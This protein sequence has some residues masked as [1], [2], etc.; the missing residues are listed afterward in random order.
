MKRILFLM[1]VLAIATANASVAEPTAFERALKRGCFLNYL[2]SYGKLSIK[3]DLSKRVVL[4]PSAARK[5]KKFTG[6]TFSLSEKSGRKLFEK[7]FRLNEGILSEQTFDLAVTGECV[8]MFRFEGGDENAEVVYPLIREVFQWENF[9]LPDTSGKVYAPFTPVKA[10]EDSA[11]VVLRKYRLNGFGLLDSILA[12]S[13]DSEQAGARPETLKQRELLAGPS[14]IAGSISGNE[15]VWREKK[16]KKISSGPQAAEWECSARSGKLEIASKARLEYDGTLKVNMSLIPSGEVSLDRLFIDIPL[17]AE[18]VPYFHAVTDAIRINDAGVLPE[19]WKSPQ[20]RRGSEWQNSFVPYIYLGGAARGLAFFAENDKNWLTAKGDMNLPIQEIIRDG[21]TVTLRI[22]LCNTPSLLKDTCSIVFG[23]QAAP[24]KPLGDNWR[25]RLRT[26]PGFSGPVNPWGGLHCASMGPYRERWDIVDDIIA[27]QEGRAFNKDVF[28][29]KIKELNPPNVLG[30]NDY[31]TRQLYFASRKDRPIL[32]YH[33]ENQGSQI[34]R[35]WA[36]FQDEWGIDNYTPREWPDEDVLR[37]GFW[38]DPS[39]RINFCPSY[40][41]YGLYYANQW[42]KRGIGLYWDNDYPTPDFN[43]RVPGGAYL[44]ENGRI[45]PAVCFWNRREYH[46]RIFELQQYWS[47]KLGK[48]LVWSHHM[49]NTMI[50][51][52]N[53]F[54]T[55]ML[56]YELHSEKP[57]DSGYILSTSAGG[58]CG[59]I[60]NALYN[61]LG[62]NNPHFRKFK[63]QNP[64]ESDL[65]VWGTSA[66]Y[67]LSVHGK[68]GFGDTLTLFEKKYP[69]KLNPIRILTDFGYGT[70]KVE[71]CPLWENPSEFNTGTDQVIHLL[72][73]HR[74]TGKHLV[75]LQN[76][77]EKDVVLR[78]V[79]SGKKL[80]IPESMTPYQTLI[81]VEDQ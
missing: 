59:A 81:I 56:D 75:L 62:S 5:A 31:L 45:Q 50:L 22:Y 16:V 12:G 30:S 70:P 7:N 10:G 33:E 44:A 69:G 38:V 19:A 67:E 68:Y 29:A 66:V 11:E 79:F 8:A 17:R 64:Y 27:S 47:E 23:L 28:T 20:A 40:I 71:V 53:G 39:S 57:F 35:E 4:L 13:P 49:T 61:L 74:E 32:V 41:K 52:F 48:R 58:K 37:R 21:K 2:P 80:N 60:G 43:L 77:S 72:L 25:M 54:A 55:V 51:P 65:A 34:R 18:E 9:E 24:V 73:R 15:I 3:V 78:P 26:D 14:V 6:V 42:L 63:E 1:A 76:I 36:V 46:K